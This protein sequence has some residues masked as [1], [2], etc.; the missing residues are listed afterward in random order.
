MKRI[1]NSE[2]RLRLADGSY[3]F[4]LGCGVPVIDDNGDI[5]EWICT[6]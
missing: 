2:H 1:Y 4:F 6:T 3:R 5:Q